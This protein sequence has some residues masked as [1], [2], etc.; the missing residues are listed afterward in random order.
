LIIQTAS[1]ALVKGL[2]VGDELCYSPLVSM[3]CLVMPLRTKDIALKNLYES[4]F[5]AQKILEMPEDVYKQAAQLRADYQ[6]L[7]TPDAIHLSTALHH[8]CDEFWTNDNR[9]DKVAPTLVKNVI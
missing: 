2:N 6:S 4:F 3:E 8:K 9:L 1:E 5:N 7:K